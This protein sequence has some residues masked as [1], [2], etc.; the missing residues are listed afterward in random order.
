M[1]LLASLGSGAAGATGAG[2]VSG[3]ATT[4]VGSSF[5]SGLFDD[6][7]KLADVNANGGGLGTASQAFS[8]MFGGQVSDSTV[9][10]LNT[11]QVGGEMKRKQADPM[12]DTRQ[13]F[14][15]WLGLMNFT[16]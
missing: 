8:K 10:D 1:N 2:A 11:F 6:A 15:D 16:N 9:K 7:T 4:A 14:Q 13:Q 5:L 3:A 12:D